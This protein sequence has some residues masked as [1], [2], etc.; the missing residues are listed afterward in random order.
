M[1]AFRKGGNMNIVEAVS[2]VAGVISIIS[3]L[4]Q[5]AKHFSLSHRRKRRGRKRHS[6]TTQAQTTTRADQSV[7]ITINIY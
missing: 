1:E 2:F 4:Y 5:I 6:Q 7:Q 3:V